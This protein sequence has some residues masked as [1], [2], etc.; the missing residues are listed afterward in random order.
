MPNFQGFM[1][2]LLVSGL[3]P[4]KLFNQLALRL[5]LCR[6]N[7]GFFQCK[8]QPRWFAMVLVWNCEA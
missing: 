1:L 2:F 6:T 3:H 8:E 5:H 4:G 7:P